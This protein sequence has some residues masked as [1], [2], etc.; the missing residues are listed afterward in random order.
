MVLTIGKKQ[1]GSPKANL[2]NE[3]PK[4]MTISHEE[5]IKPRN[6]QLKL[7]RETA[8]LSP[9]SNKLLTK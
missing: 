4:A 8:H 1:P 9:T 2:A 7:I 5:L 6:N 3:K